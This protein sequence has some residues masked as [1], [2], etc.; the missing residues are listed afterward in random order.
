MRLEPLG[1]ADLSLA[2]LHIWIHARQFP[3][4]TDYWDGN[5]LRVT[6]C[7]ISPES[8]VRAHGP[9][10][11]LGELVG[12]LKGCERLYQT[13]VGRARLNCL[14]PNLEVSLDATANGHIK[15]EIAITSDHIAETH[16][17]LDEIDQTYL[18]PIV[19]ACRRILERFPVREPEKLPG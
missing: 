13:L 1:E 5:W 10:I 14:E 2:G 19:A 8:T 3:E 18:P 12:L 6:A 7:C 4:A 9:I 17:Y 16:R 15:V 11:H